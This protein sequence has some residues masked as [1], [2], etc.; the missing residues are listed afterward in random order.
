ME[1]LGGMQTMGSLQ[2][3]VGI[4]VDKSVCELHTAWTAT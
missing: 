2:T 3:N 1:L 4:G